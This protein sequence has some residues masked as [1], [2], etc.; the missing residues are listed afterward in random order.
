MNNEHL[1]FCHSTKIDTNVIR[2]H[3]SIIATTCYLDVV[4]SVSDSLVPYLAQVG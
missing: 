2:R 3:H 1:S 4:Y